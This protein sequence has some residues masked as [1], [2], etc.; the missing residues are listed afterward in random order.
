MFHPI[1]DLTVN[2]SWMAVCVMA[3]AGMARCPCFSP[4]VNQTTSPGRISPTEQPSRWASVVVADVSKEDNRETAHM[5]EELSGRLDAAFNS[6][7]STS[8]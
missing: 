6:A 3:V 7:V 1:D 4:A 8:R 5:I 2:L